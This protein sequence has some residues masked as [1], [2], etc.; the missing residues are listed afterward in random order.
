MVLLCYVIGD[1]GFVCILL[2]VDLYD[3]CNAWFD[4]VWLFITNIG[5]D[6][7]KRWVL[8]FVIKVVGKPGLLNG[9]H[10]PINTGLYFRVLSNPQQSF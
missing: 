7:G 4:D 10:G 8:L 2:N 6:D 1:R 5:L 3:I 9:G